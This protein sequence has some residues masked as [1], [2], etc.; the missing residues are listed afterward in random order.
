MLDEPGTTRKPPSERKRAIDDAVA[1]A[2]GHR[3]RIDAL[4]ILAEGKHSPNEIAEILGEDVSLIGNH[5]RELFDSGCIE[6]AGTAKV[7]NATEH[8]Y[9]A[10]TLPYVSDEAY[11]EMPHETRREIIGLIIQAITAEVMASFRAGKLEADED[12]WMV[13][14][15][16]NLDAQ[17]RRE[18]GDELAARYERFI[19]IKA[20][21][22]SR[23]AKSGD[24]GT[25]TL[26]ALMGFERSRP[27]RPKSGYPAFPDPEPPI[28]AQ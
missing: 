18:L 19:E 2:V 28:D 12:L 5:V 17:G 10:V 20:K 11:R 13:W 14:D 22:A 7:R 24:T 27:G 15:S 3:I 9:R 4:A 25:M 23:L 6:S 16:M 1:Y 26:V 21:S 8:F